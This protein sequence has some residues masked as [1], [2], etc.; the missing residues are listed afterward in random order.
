MS[1]PKL[2]HLRLRNGT[3]TS[4]PIKRLLFVAEKGDANSQFN[5]GVLHD[6]RLDD[7]NH[8]TGGNRVG[9]IKWLR[10]AAQQGLPRAACPAIRERDRG[11]RRLRK[12]LHLVHP[13]N[14]ELERH[15]SPKG[16]VRIR[17]DLFAHDARADRRGETSCK[18]TGSRRGRTSWQ[19]GIIR[20]F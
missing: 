14:D 17:A 13:C 9:A 6:N 11:T 5:L 3:M 15:T 19:R 18:K 12:G 16:S 4:D 8:P 2:R 7:N 10:R 20:I 1:G